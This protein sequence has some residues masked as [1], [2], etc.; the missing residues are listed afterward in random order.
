MSKVIDLQKY[1]ENKLTEKRS[2][3]P[4]YRFFCANCEEPE[5][6]SVNSN[7][8]TWFMFVHVNNHV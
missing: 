3:C 8:N 2:E 6:T 4:K 1:R 5:F 7:K